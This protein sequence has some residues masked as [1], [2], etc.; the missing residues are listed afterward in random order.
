LKRQQ[1]KG[2]EGMSE[3]RGEQKTRK[4]TSEEGMSKGSVMV[5][6]KRKKGQVKGEHRDE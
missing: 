5:K 6:A 1:A 3:G 2:H 4:E